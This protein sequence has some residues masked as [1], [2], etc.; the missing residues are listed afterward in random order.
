M[1]NMS[2]C[3]F[4]NTLQDLRDCADALDEIEGNLAELNKEE[5]RAADALILLCRE[6]AEK[7]GDS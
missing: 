1:S 2:Y 4:Q 7:A 5:A 3:R 6:I